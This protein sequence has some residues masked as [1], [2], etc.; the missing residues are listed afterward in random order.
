MFELIIEYISLYYYICMRICILQGGTME[1]AQLWLNLPS[2][3]KMTAP[4]YQAI[5]S[6]DIPS[7]P[8]HAVPVEGEEECAVVGSV[9]IIAGS[10]NGQEG[11][12]TTHTPVELF[13]VTIHVRIVYLSFVHPTITN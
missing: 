11:A 13:D 1:M 8:L 12:A 4:A 10:L 5:L 6:T 7:I 2:S 3:K 9:R